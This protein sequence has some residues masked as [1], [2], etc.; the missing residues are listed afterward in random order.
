MTFWREVGSNLKGVLIVTPPL[1]VVCAAALL[2]Y[3]LLKDL[4]GDAALAVTF[5]VAVIG[6]AI[7]MAALSRVMK[8]F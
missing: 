8:Y 1:A 4:I 2:P 3:V 5:V 6:V 7:M